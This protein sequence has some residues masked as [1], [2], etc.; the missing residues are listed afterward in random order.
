MDFACTM[1]EVVL[2][3]CLLA[4]VALATC[5]RADDRWV[6]IRS[7]PFHILTRDAEKNARLVLNELEQIRHVLGNML[8]KQDLK[9][10]WPVRIVV[11]KDRRAAVYPEPKLARDAYVASLTTVLPET[12]TRIVQLLIDSNAG[13]LPTAFENGLVTLFST[14]EADGTH[15]TLGAA[16]ARKDRDWSR[17][18]ML[19]TDPRFTGKV[20][21]LFSNLQQGA[22]LEPAYKNAFE[23]TAEQI[24]REVDRY[25]EAGQYGTA[26]PSARAI[27]VERS[28]TVRDAEQKVAELAELDILVAN[29]KAGPQEYAKFPGAENAP[30]PLLK[31]GRFEAAAKANPLWAEPWWLEAQKEQSGLRRVQLL[32]KATQLAPRKPEYWLALAR[33][34]EGAEQ[35]AAAVKSWA[36]AERAAP[37]R[38]EKEQIRQSLRAGEEMRTEK[39]RLEREEERRKAQAEVEALR[40]RSLADIR[41]AEARA[42]AG[43]APLDPNVKLEE[44]RE[45]MGYEKVGG[46]L[47]RVDC[48]GAMPGSHS[49]PGA[50]QPSGSWSSIP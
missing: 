28:F 9:S 11:V 23:M 40:Q 15:L 41:L 13:P 25:I 3:R 32:T 19:V 10:V 34:Q 17:V 12:R 46:R 49:P 36:A 35:F 26:S 38:A 27:S 4:L 50:A 8:A 37:S 1:V 42:N 14:F 33:A 31:A 43:K 6:E 18:N 7:G 20:R 16:P 44:Y 22:D 30:V 5:L 39:L 48:L 45:N 47:D 29:G 24:E 21:V 2:L